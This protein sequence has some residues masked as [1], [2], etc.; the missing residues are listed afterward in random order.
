MT[1]AGAIEIL[2]MLW[3]PSEILLGIFRRANPGQDQISDRGSGALLWSVLVFAVLIAVAVRGVSWGRLPLPPAF[4]EGLAALFL[5]G[6]IGVRWW[7]ITT[8]GPAFT[9]NVAVRPEHRVITSGP[10]RWVRHPAYSGML[11]AFLGCGWYL[12]SW[13]SL[14]LLLLPI[15]AAILYR[16][17][18]EEDALVA[19]LGEEYEAYR[20]RTRTFLPGSF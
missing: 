20:R 14:G 16:V 4:L 13:L 6:G 15:S 8:L 3:V 7:A 5:V 1:L 12:G 11:F 18:V 9:T 2:L 10:Y 17:K 19:A